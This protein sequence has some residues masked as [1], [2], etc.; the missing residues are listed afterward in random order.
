MNVNKYPH[1]GHSDGKPGILSVKWILIFKANIRI[2]EKDPESRKI[3][4]SQKLG[5]PRSRSENQR[6]DFGDRK[7]LQSDQISAKSI[8][9]G[10]QVGVWIMDSGLQ[11]KIVSTSTFV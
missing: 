11:P 6:T 3:D 2:A 4:R 1:G 10:T 9:S 7:G 8:R 5:W